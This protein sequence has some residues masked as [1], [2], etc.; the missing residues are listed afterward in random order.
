MNLRKVVITYIHIF[1][2]VSVVLWQMYVVR[3]L[4]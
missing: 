1:F 3:L 2:Y 4:L